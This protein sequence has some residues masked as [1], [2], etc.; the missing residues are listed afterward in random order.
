LK[1]QLMFTVVIFLVLASVAPAATMGFVSDTSWAVNG[2]FAQAVCLNSS[3]P[4]TCPAGA[5]IYG[6]A[7]AGWGTNL[8]AIPGAAWI[9]GPGVTGATTPAE[10]ANFTFTKSFFLNGTPT[11]GSILISADDFGSV[12]VNGSQVGTVGSTTNI[13]LA[14]QQANLATFDLTSFL[15]PGLNTI[16]VTVQNG[17]DAFAGC[18]GCTFA[19]NPAG[20]VFGGSLAFNGAEVPEPGTISLFAAG[21]ALLAIG[22]YR[23]A[24]R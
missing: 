16:A 6:Y 1:S 19:Q 13:A 21:I 4:A 22:R 23:Y 5:T 20:A 10:L 18:T 3:A 11:G 7:G 14:G 15:Y 12:S 17:V 9:L 8:A 2:G 24:K